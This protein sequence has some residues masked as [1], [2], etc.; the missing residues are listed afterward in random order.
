VVPLGDLYISWSD[1]GPTGDAS[2]ADEE[3]D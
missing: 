3:D 1:S 2:Q